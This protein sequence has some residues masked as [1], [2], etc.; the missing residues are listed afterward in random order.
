MNGL[1]DPG[2]IRLLCEASCAGVQVDLLVRGICCLRPGIPGVSENIRV[3]SIVGRSCAG[4][5]RGRI[6]SPDRERFALRDWARDREGRAS[7]ISIVASGESRGG[8]RPRGGI[9]VLSLAKGEVISHP[10]EIGNHGH[11]PMRYRA[12]FILWGN[13]SRMKRCRSFR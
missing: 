11:W 9:Y 12:V 10:Q 2:M 1:D 8:V 3:R 6:S 7:E 4:R 5:T 13:L